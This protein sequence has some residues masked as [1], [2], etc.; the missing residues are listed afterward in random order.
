MRKGVWPCTQHPLTSI[1]SFIS[2]LLREE[3]LELIHE[4]LQDPWWKE[5]L[6]EEMKAL[7]KK[8]KPN[9]GFSGQAQGNML[10]GCKW[11]FAGK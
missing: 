1:S 7:E 11:V 10:V 6:M 3:V 4:A 2:K 9:L 8:K 5:A